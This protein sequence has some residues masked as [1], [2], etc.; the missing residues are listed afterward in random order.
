MGGFRIWN[1]GGPRLHRSVDGG[2]GRGKGKVCPTYCWYP[3]ATWHL[4]Y[5]VIVLYAAQQQYRLL[6]RQNLPESRS[7]LA[8]YPDYPAWNSPQKN[9][10]DFEGGG[11]MYSYTPIFVRSCTRTPLP[12]HKT[13]HIIS[14]VCL[15]VHALSIHNELTATWYSGNESNVYSGSESLTTSTCTLHLGI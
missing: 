8:S 5:C 14:S 15:F 6:T 7:H 9:S 2:E 11:A 12:S 1:I 3:T 13:I 10:Q 4:H